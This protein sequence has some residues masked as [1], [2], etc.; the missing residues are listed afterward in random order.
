MLIS[1]KSMKLHDVY[2]EVLIFYAMILSWESSLLTTELQDVANWKE[3]KFMHLLK[4]AEFPEY[5]QGYH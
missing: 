4:L 3:I 5:W 1:V 2:S